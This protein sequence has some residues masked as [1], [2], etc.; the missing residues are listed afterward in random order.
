MIETKIVVWLDATESPAGSS[1]T[2]K[3]FKYVRYT[4]RH[5]RPIKAYK[6]IPDLIY[7]LE[8]RSSWMTEER[9]DWEA[10]E[11]QRILC[12][13]DTIGGNFSRSSDSP[14]DPIDH[15]LRLTL[16]GRMSSFI[17]DAPY[18]RSNYPVVDPKWEVVDIPMAASWYRCGQTEPRIMRHTS[19]SAVDLRLIA[20]KLSTLDFHKLGYAEGSAAALDR[21]V[22]NTRS[23]AAND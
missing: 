4:L 5:E 12:I 17:M 14:V 9:A 13:L 19:Y 6:V 11:L 20:E 2:N 7:R 8:K 21:A 15:P 10:L 18:R 22:F 16:G 1:I 3:S 23:E